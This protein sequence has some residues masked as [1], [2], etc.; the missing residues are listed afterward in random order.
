MPTSSQVKHRYI[1]KPQPSSVIS[2][3]QRVYTGIT[4]C[5]NKSTQSE[6]VNRL[7]GT[8]PSTGVADSQRVI[9]ND[10]KHKAGVT[11]SYQ[12]TAGG[13]EHHGFVW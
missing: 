9:T 8:V 2:G 4:R 7:T 12:W 10:V 11:H 6:C 13:Q 3:Y 5:K 1:A